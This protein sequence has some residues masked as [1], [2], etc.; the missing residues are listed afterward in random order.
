MTRVIET[1][2]IGRLVLPPE[3]LGAVKPHTRYTVEISPTSVTLKQEATKNASPERPDDQRATEHDAWMQE[4]RA[5]ARQIDAA[6]RGEKSA[7]QE[8]TDMRDARG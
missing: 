1:D 7:L 6:W 8:L 5:L 4:W 3:I 2:E